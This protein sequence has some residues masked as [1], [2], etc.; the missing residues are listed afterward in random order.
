[1]VRSDACQWS[2]FSTCKND[3]DLLSDSD[4]DGEF[5]LTKNVLE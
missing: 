4:I 1:M 3:E 5:G 2:S